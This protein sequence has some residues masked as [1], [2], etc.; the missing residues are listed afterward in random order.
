MS[1]NKIEA[2]IW[3]FAIYSIT[4]KRTYMTFLTIYLLMMPSA[5]AKTIGVLTAVGQITG[6]LFEIPSGYISDRIGHKNALVFSRIFF[7][8]STLCYVLANSI[9]WFFLGA[10]FLAIGFAFMSGTGSAFMHDT[11]KEIGK[12]KQY[13]HIMGRVQSL[14]FAVPI[15]FIILLP[16]IAETSFKLAFLTVLVIDIVG[17]LVALSMTNPNNEGKIEEI[18]IVNF[19]QT[20]REWFNAG[21]FRYILIGSI[22]FG[23]SFGATAGFK[24]P[25][26][27]M[28]GFSITSLGFLWAGSRVLISGLLL[29][30]GWVY[31]TF[32]YKQFIIMRTV[33]YALC[34]LGIGL[35]SNM[36]VVAVMFMIQAAFMWGMSPVVAQYNLEFIKTSKSKATL[37]SI[38]QLIEK[39]F[40]TIFGFTMGFLVLGYSYPPSSLIMGIILVV[41]LIFAMFYLKNIKLPIS[42][43]LVL[44]EE[45]FSEA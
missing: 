24:N 33:I 13:A 43:K 20:I 4:N 15:I 14:G 45:P 28:I 26:Q 18:S 39:I 6:F 3:K 25:H 22:V 34:C 29:F 9:P 31:K 37:L 38:N 32:S 7:I 19:K 5:T 44:V 30:N 41:I 36:W 40:T 17:F 12:D 10:I 21:W 8:F 35:I 1:Q 2:N 27:E 23:V 16:F 42:S 11:L